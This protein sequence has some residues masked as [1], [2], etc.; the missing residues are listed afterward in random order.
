MAAPERYLLAEIMQPLLFGPTCTRQ[1]V[2]QFA[3]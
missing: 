1:L 2:L 3:V